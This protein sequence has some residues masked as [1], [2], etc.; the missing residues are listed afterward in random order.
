MPLF[1]QYFK[2]RKVRIG[3]YPGSYRWR[4]NV[5]NNYISKAVN[6]RGIKIWIVHYFNIIVL[7]LIATNE[8]HCDKQPKD[9]FDDT[10]MKKRF[11]FILKQLSGYLKSFCKDGFSIFLHF[12]KLQKEVNLSN[13]PYVS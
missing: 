2:S 11:H 4:K 7:F 3:I 1:S 9:Q 13:L 8:L 10:S 12:L 6:H 5:V